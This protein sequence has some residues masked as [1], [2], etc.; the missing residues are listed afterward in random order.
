MMAWDME[1]STGVKKKLWATCGIEFILWLIDEGW[2]RE[3]LEK[4]K[5]FAKLPMSSCVCGS[6]IA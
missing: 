5:I 3:T 1:I 2:E 4:S 6:N